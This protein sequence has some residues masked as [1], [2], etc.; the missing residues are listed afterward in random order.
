MC[1]L[2]FED[3]AAVDLSISLFREFRFNTRTCAK[4]GKRTRKAIERHHVFPERYKK[5][6]YKLPLCDEC[7]RELEG[8]IAKAE[9]TAGGSLTPLQFVHVTIYFL[10]YFYTNGKYAS[11]GNGNGKAKTPSRKMHANYVFLTHHQQS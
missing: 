7:H 1:D 9:T 4:C 11:N 8:L 5:N 10:S 6:P 3:V 2:S